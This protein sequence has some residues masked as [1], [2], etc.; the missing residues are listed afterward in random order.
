MVLYLCHN[1]NLG[2][3]IFKGGKAKMKKLLVMLLCLLMLFSLCACAGNSARRTVYERVSA[4]LPSYGRQYF[5][6]LE[7]NKEYHFD[8]STYSKVSTYF[9]SS[10]FSKFVSYCPD[11]GIIILASSDGCYFTMICKKDGS[12]VKKYVSQSDFSSD[13]DIEAFDIYASLF[14]H[15]Y[16]SALEDE[17]GAYVIGQSN[18]KYKVTT[19]NAVIEENHWYEFY[20]K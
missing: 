18:P 13:E 2:L 20:L 17:S 8:E 5:Y 11:E 10:A 6:A 4:N 15:A 16:Y 19:E 7:Y 1:N 3:H 14:Y 9:S 12:V